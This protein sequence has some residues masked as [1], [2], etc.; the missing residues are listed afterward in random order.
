MNIDEQLRNG[1]SGMVSC[2]EEEYRD[3]V[4]IET[5]DEMKN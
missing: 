2:K 1:L 5:D 3:V 4:F